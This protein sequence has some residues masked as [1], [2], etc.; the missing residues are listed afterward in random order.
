M[1]LNLISENVINV[2][3]GIFDSGFEVMLRVPIKH[4]LIITLM[5]I[6]MGILAGILVVTY[7]FTPY[8]TLL[9]IILG[10]L[11]LVN[12]VLIGM[13]IKKGKLGNA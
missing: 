11:V 13:A 7:D 12:I 1:T 9:L 2:T 4:S 6:G 3:R 5:S 8:R 10:A